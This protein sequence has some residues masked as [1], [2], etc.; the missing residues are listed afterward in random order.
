[1]KQTAQW[2][3]DNHSSSQANRWYEGFLKVLVSLEKNPDRFP[4]ARESAA[5]PVEMR[6]LHFGLGRR[7]THRAI[8]AIRQDSVVI[9]AIRHTAQ[10][11]VTADE[12]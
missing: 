10:D 4:F 9:Y 8:F 7:K 6:E 3:A 5:L 11:D 12:L 2:W 1:L